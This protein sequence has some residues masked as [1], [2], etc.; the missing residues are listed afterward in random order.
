[1]LRIINI[2]GARP[3]FMKIAPLI[4]AMR[5]QGGIDALLVH[6][7]QH[8]DDNLSKIFFDELG[9]PRPDIDLGIG[10]GSREEQI[11]AI[12][13]AFRE[14]I[15]TH[16]CDAVLVVGDVNSTIACARVAKE[17]K[18]CVIHV[19]A[20]LRSFDQ[21]MPEELNRCETD[22]ISDL[23][24]V[25]EES[26]IRNLAQE[27]NPGQHFLVGNVMI[28]TLIK[29]LPGAEKSTILEQLGIQAHSY[30][31]ATFHRPSNV[32]AL[33]DL[34]RLVDT[35]EK[36]CNLTTLVLPL[37][38]RTR[39]ALIRHQ[40]MDRTQSI[41]NLLLC[42]PLGYLD[43]LRLISSAQCV[44]T[45][46]GG[47]QEETTWLG[48]PCIT[49]RENTERPVTIESGTNILVGSNEALLMENLKAI[50]N[51]DFKVGNKPPLWDGQAAQRI[52]AILLKELQH[53]S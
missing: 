13:I 1:M 34:S 2:V 45:D 4:A 50:L 10:S 37:H 38:P 46:S 6:T 32:D 42:E 48:I 17:Q 14:I 16:P 27:S 15:K 47:I 41:K 23:L 3:N 30:T 21:E 26:G 7:G 51:G 49:M 24:F 19:E 35:I 18:L 25:T 31:A 44:V 9:I 53:N 39:Q 20:G 22:A 11:A 36:I 28:D 5:A 33:E 52:V 8:Y 29:N 12:E 43:F 40:L